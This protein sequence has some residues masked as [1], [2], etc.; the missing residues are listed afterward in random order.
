MVGCGELQKP[1]EHAMTDYVSNFRKQRDI[2]WNPDIRDKM[3][4]LT[5]ANKE[6][7]KEIPEEHQKQIVKNYVAMYFTLAAINWCHGMTLGMAW[8]K[9]LE[10]MDAYIKS[11]TK[12][13][14]HPMRKYLTEMHAIRRREMAK[15]IMTN[16]H[17]NDKLSL[18]PETA[19]KWESFS[20]KHFQKNKNA[21]NMLYK[22][23]MPKQPINVQ[24]N[25]NSFKVAQEKMF[26]KMQ[27][28]LLQ[29]KMAQRAA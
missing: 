29:Q 2:L 8:Q 25:E 1:K 24:T 12:I 16:P 28:I 5:G 22:Q 3:A 7:Q 18:N 13:A 27:Q 21:L 11:K 26:T 10:Q 4:I 17:A 20:T 19:A 23:Y 6:H 15:E 14:N 9:A